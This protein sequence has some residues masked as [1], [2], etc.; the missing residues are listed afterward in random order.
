MVIAAGLRLREQPGFKLR[1]EIQSNRHEFPSACSLLQTLPLARRPPIVHGERVQAETAPACERRPECLHVH[2]EQRQRIILN[3]KF[4]DVGDVLCCAR[5]KS[6]PCSVFI[7]ESDSSGARPHAG[8]QALEKY[9]VLNWRHASAFD[10]VVAAVE[11]LADFGNLLKVSRHRIF[12]EIV[13]RK[14]AREASS[15]KRDSVSGLRCTSIGV[16]ESRDV[17][18]LCQN[19]C[20]EKG[21]ARRAAIFLPPAVHLPFLLPCHMYYGRR[22]APKSYAKAKFLSRHRDCLPAVRVP[23]DRTFASWLFLL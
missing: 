6:K 14:A 18:P 21:K 16:C 10:V 22:N 13:G 23:A 19:N 20:G 12:H 5:V 15:F 11:H 1:V 7:S 3:D 17:A 9:F 4:P 2:A 8:R